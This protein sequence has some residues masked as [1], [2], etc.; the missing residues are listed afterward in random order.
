MVLFANAESALA[1]LKGKVESISIAKATLQEESTPLVSWFCISVLLVN[2]ANMQ[3][4]RIYDIEQWNI[5]SIQQDKQ[6]FWNLLRGLRL[7]TSTKGLELVSNISK[8]HLASNSTTT[9]SGL[10]SSWI[11][12]CIVMS[13]LLPPNSLL[14]LVSLERKSRQL[15]GNE[16]QSI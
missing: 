1:A 3:H 5:M 8:P 12:A 4:H 16:R 2:D 6:L 13:S 14:L 7:N 15:S 9:S 10:R 11:A